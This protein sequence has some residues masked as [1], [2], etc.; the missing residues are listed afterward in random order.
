METHVVDL[1]PVLWI[2]AFAIWFLGLTAIGYLIY[3]IIK[4]K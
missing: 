4:G 3:S 2:L 1:V